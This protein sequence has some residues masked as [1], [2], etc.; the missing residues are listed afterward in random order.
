MS[1]KSKAASRERRKREKRS[2]KEANRARYAAMRDAGQNRKKKE[3]NQT[4]RATVRFKR[5][6]NGAC[7]NLGC[8]RCSELARELAARRKG[9]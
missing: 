3:G 8:T 4:G 2:R 6:P 9:D 5:H 1:K 7:G